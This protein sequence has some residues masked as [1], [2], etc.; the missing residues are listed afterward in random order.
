MSGKG[1]TEM[2]LDFAPPGWGTWQ[3]DRAHNPKPMTR[4]ALETAAEHFGL[5]FNE[6]MGSYGVPI[7][8]VTFDHVHGY[9]YLRIQFAGDPGPDGPP[10]EDEL[11]GFI[12][13]CA[14]RA[15]AAL[16]GRM[17]RDDIERWDNEVKPTA[18]AAHRSLGDVDLA[19]LDQA[20]L[21]AHLERCLA[22][23]RA[24]VT[25]HHR[26]NASAMFP[27]ADL[28][29]Q[30]MTWTGLPPTLLLG[31]MEGSSPISGTWSSEIEPAAKAV[32]LD[33]DAAALLDADG[34][35]GERLA[36]LR[37]RVP[38]VDE[39]VR[40]VGMRLVDGFDLTGRTLIE[41]PG[42]L[43]G[44][45][46]AAVA[47]GGPPDRSDLAALEERVRAAVPEEHRSAF[48]DLLAEARLTYRLRDERGVYS[49]MSGTGLTRLA[50]L[51][52]GRRL[53]AT[54][55][56]ADPEHLFD[57]SSDELL[58]IAAGASAPTADELRA[59]AELRAAAALATSP[60]MLG[61]PPSPP[62]PLE[63][64]PPALARVV[65]GIGFAIGSILQGI[66][67]PTVA[68]GV[69]SGLP[70]SGGVV[71]GTARVI[72]DL[73]QLLELEQG[74]ILVS[75]TTSE[76]FNSA[77]HLVGAIVTDHG[78]IASHAAIVS[79]EVGIPAVVGTGVAS[80]TISDG[81]RIR[82][83]GNTGEVTLLS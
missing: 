31:L 45:L 9:P 49:D 14:E 23:G 75:A 17:W 82:V 40:T 36:Q 69:I 26:F 66:E 48:D 1:E 19:A 79:R 5:G 62:P 8:S 60:P 24:M 56:V 42:L 16:A 27:V 30:T 67:A 76:A 81:A 6:A 38:E 44:K 68:G 20:A 2:T 41:M 70:G 29:T 33:V 77:I 52:L 64:L 35:T 7:R 57:V 34:D 15:E 18:M 65:G 51:E 10:S 61:D 63:L 11:F 47:M 28:V 59:R 83:D 39:W 78:G 25:Q 37:A 73:D 71:E 3:Q 54:G 46:A 12:G 4:L 43:L 74:D 53:V 72:T 13:Q 21:I 55:R 22:H 80:T 50:V 32:S 58:A